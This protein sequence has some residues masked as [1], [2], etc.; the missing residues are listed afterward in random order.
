[1]PSAMLRPCSA[2]GGCPELVSSGR[3]PK[4]ALERTRTID[5]YRGTSAERG[6]DTRWSKFSRQFRLRHPFCGDRPHGLPPTGDSVCQ[7]DGIEMAAALVDHIVPITG[8]NDA[9]KYD[10]TNLASLCAVCHNI[11]RQRESMAQRGR[12]R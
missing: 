11:K 12:V 3:C 8:P 9:R 6:Y 5:R 4:H 7:R 10:D 2:P 1:M